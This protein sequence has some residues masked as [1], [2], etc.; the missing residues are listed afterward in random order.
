MKETLPLYLIHHL[1]GF[2]YYSVLGTLSVEFPS[3]KFCLQ[4]KLNGL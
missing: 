1:A 4:L 3:E 2:N